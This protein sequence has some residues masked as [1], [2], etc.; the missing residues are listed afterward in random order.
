MSG[1]GEYVHLVTFEAPGP[2][3]P[4]GDGGYT[5]GWTAL[6]PPTWYVA[7]RAATLR[8]RETVLAGV[9]AASATHVVTGD[10]R[11][12]VTTATRIRYTDFA[13]LEHMFAIAGVNNIDLRGI[14]MELY[15]EER[16]P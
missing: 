16:V 3:V 15:V 9:V 10:Y 8:D 7:I 4:D 14:L 1:R 13:G 5:Q 12:D 11:Y 2:A 6:D